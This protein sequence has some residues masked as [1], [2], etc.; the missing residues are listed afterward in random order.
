MWNDSGNSGGQWKRAEINLGKL[1]NFEV[2][3]EGIRAKDLGG[4]AAIDDIEY[5]NC[6]TKHPCV[7][8]EMMTSLAVHTR[9]DITTLAATQAEA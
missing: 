4:G 7:I 9:S 1:R 8:G 2:I 5:K 3:F 6:S